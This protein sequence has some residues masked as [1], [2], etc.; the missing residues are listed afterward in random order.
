MFVNLF[1]LV[2]NTVELSY[3]NVV[4]SSTY[5]VFNPLMVRSEHPVPDKPENAP[6]FPAT[7]AV[8]IPKI[9]VTLLTSVPL[10]THLTVLLL[11]MVPNVCNDLAICESDESYHTIGL[12]DNG[13]KSEKG[14]TLGN[15]TGGDES[16]KEKPHLFAKYVRTRLL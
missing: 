10:L 2:P 5:I 7:T 11:V 4:S 3:N 1:E 13:V 12:K 14:L 16:A 8:E 15:T 6:N 9:G